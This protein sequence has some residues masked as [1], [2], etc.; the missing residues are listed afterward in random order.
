MA[1]L[2]IGPVLLLTGCFTSSDPVYEE[3][4]VFQD[5]RIEGQFEGVTYERN[6]GSIWTIRA[7]EDQKGKYRIFLKDG[8]AQI[9]LVGTLFRLDEVTFFDLYPVRDSGMNRSGGGPIDAQ[10]SRPLR[11]VRAPSCHLEGQIS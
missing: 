8:A 6:D 9:E 7:S 10:R 4:Q 3:G 1:N 2:A 11:A 5:N